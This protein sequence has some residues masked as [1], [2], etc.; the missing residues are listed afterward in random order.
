MSDDVVRMERDATGTWCWP[1]RMDVLLTEAASAAW[2]Q[3]V[4]DLG[5]LLHP[6]HE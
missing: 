3:M 1:E 4:A 6:P 5:D 2:E